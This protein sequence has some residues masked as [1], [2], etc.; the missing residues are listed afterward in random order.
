MTSRT[1]ALIVFLVAL[2]ARGLYVAEVERSDLLA[3]PVGDELAFEPWARDVADGEVR[4]GVLYQAP[5]AA[6]AMGAAHALLGDDPLVA[7]A[8]HALLGALT[9]ALVADLARRRFGARVGLAAGLG[10]AL[11]APAIFHAARLEK[12]ALGLFAVALA[13]VAA[14]R[15][16]TRATRGRVLVFGAALAVAGLAWESAWVLLPWALWIVLRAGGGARG[17]AALVA[18]LA[19]GF[20]PQVARN[21]AA[22]APPLATTANLGPNLWIGNRPG[23]DGLYLPLVPG[24]GRTGDEERD[25]RE[26][27]ERGAGRALDAAEVSAYWRDRALAAIAAE[28]GRAARLAGRKLA[29]ALRDREWMDSVDYGAA[30]GESRVLAWLGGPLRF[31]V[32]LPLAAVGLALGAG[33]TRARVE[34]VVPA[35]LFLG[36]LGAF[37]VLGRLRLPV[38]LALAPFAAAAPGALVAAIRARA[39]ARIAGAAV[40]ALVALGLARPWS[41]AQADPAAEAAASWNNVASVLRARGEDDRAWALLRRAAA[42]APDDPNVRFSYGELAAERGDVEGARRALAAAARLEPA[43]AAEAEIVLAGAELAAGDAAGALARLEVAARLPNDRPEVPYRAGRVYARAGELEQARRAYLAAL[44]L[45][46]DYPEAANDL[47]WLYERAGRREPARAAYE[48]ALAAD[49][50]FVASLFNL[51]RLLAG[52]PEAELRDGERALALSARLAA[53]QG[54]T[55]DVLDLRAMAL[56]EGGRYAEAVA[57]AEE[58]LGL[59]ERAGREEFAGGIARRLAAYRGGLPAR[60]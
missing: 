21:L 40:A 27:A 22:D 4:P 43:F 58:A 30:R 37:F 28:P 36:G 47:G 45:R 60:D 17:G 1:S 38:A 14:Q 32:L 8:L 52:A 49:P 25:A 26:L 15:V 56:A 39:R 18:G 16:G 41:A 6:W 46:P 31:G 54:E 57:S 3:V 53:L 13:L 19:L 51:G 33:G 10:W 9:A 35:L 50:E 59:A 12:P 5:A 34:L 55:A 2:L 20:A 11:Y 23:A 7:R 42:L 48:R 24:Q 44:E 29:L